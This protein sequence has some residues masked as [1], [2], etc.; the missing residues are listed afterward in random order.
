[1]EGVFNVSNYAFFEFQVL[2]LQGFKFLLVDYPT[3]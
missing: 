2:N 1:M 3:P